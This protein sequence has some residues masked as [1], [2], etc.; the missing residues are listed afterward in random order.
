MNENFRDEIMKRI[1]GEVITTLMFIA[2]Q[3]EMMS[4][5][6][7][8]MTLADLDSFSV[9]QLVLSLEDAYSVELLEDIAEFNGR[10]FEELEEFVALRVE[11]THGEQ[12]PS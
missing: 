10:T 12:I 4:S 11:R 5:L 8:G 2:D 6:P 3:D 7:E 9:V 1:E